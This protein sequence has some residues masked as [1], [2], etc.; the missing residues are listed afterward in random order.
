VFN[1]CVSVD[2]SGAL[3]VW[4]CDDLTLCDDDIP[5]VPSALQW[6][7]KSTTTKFQIRKTVPLGVAFAPN[8]KMM[9]VP[10]S[11]IAIRADFEFVAT[12]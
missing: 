8:G 3:E 2:D 7:Q 6:Q 10:L 1:C 11:L 5:P 12:V 9:A 4:S